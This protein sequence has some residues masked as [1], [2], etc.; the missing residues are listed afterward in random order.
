MHLRDQRSHNIALTIARPKRNRGIRVLA[1]VPLFI[2]THTMKKPGNQISSSIAN[3]ST[4]FAPRAMMIILYIFVA[5]VPLAY[6]P[7][8]AEF[9]GQ[10]DDFYYKPKLNAGLFLLG[11]AGFFWLLRFLGKDHPSAHYNRIFL[12]T[13]AFLIVLAV[14]AA[15]SPYRE[16]AFWGRRRRSEGLLAF[17]MYALALFLV[18]TSTDSRSKVRKLA[19]ALMLGACVASAYGLYQFFFYKPGLGNDLLPRDYV[20]VS[21]W[22]AFATSGNPG[23][24][25]AYLLLVLPFPVMMFLMPDSE[26]LS[27]YVR[28]RRRSRLWLAP[29]ML[30]FSCLLATYHRGAWVGLGAAGVLCIVLLRCK[31]ARANKVSSA[32][33]VVLLTALA[34]CAIATDRFAVATGKPSL[35]Q[36]ASAGVVTPDIRQSTIYTRIYIWRAT[37]PLIRAHPALGWG[38]DTMHFVFPQYAPKPQQLGLVGKVVGKPDKPENLI[39]QIAYEGGFAALTFFVIIVG[40]SLKMAARAA[41]RLTGREKALAL[42]VLIGSAAHLAQQQFSFSTL[43][44]SP[45]FWSVMGLAVALHRLS[46]GMPARHSPLR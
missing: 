33:I 26:D 4:S 35:L 6:S 11:L 34:A 21:W 18:A 31:T 17:I 1:R 36:R 20:R 23:F 13:A 46:I 27:I 32:R 42:S 39:L 9:E 43:S 2:Y 41:S 22:R 14:A 25:S 5:F 10:F 40:L 45:V 30:I 24:L 7:E 19:N 44:S 8:G 38:P 28:S 12:F 3:D 15:L 37:L 29:A 16:F